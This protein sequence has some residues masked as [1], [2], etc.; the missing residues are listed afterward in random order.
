MRTLFF[1]LSLVIIVMSSSELFSMQIHIYI[2]PERTITLEVEA[3]DAIES[4]KAKIED[5]EGIPIVQ[6]KIFF[7]S[8]ELLNGFDLAYYNIPKESTLVL[9]Q[10][11]MVPISPKSGLII[12]ASILVL[13]SI[14]YIK[15]NFV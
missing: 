10:S 12:L 4:V 6:Q 8:Q 7:N 5:R 3:G 11:E 13:I 9:V 1:C 14:Y 15:K 2:S